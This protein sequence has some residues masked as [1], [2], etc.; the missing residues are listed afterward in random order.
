MKLAILY[1]LLPLMASAGLVRLPLL[2]YEAGPS[3]M[4]R[5][6]TASW[7]RV[8]RHASMPNHQLRAAPV[9]GVCDSGGTQLSGYLDTAADKHFFFW[10][11]EAKNKPANGTAPMVVWLNGGPG[12]SSMVGALT[13]L[14]PCLVAPDGKSTVDNPYGWNQNANLL[15]IDQP[16]GTGFSHGSMVNNS[17]SAADD[18]VAML[19]LFYKTYPEYHAD[20]LHVFGESFAGHFIPAIGSAIVDHNAR[21]ARA[22]SKASDPANLHIPLT[23]IGIGN[24]L[25]DPKTQFKYYSKMACDSTYP[26]VLPQ[27]TCASMDGNHTACASLIDTCYDKQDP[28]S[29][30]FA[31]NICKIAITDPYDKYV[32]NNV[33]DVRKK[34]GEAKLCYPITEAASQFLNMSWVQHALNAKDTKFQEC[35]G[36]VYK[37][38]RAGYDYMRSYAGDLAKLLDEG[39]RT[40]IYAGDADWIC[41]WY[42]VKAVMQELE[43]CGKTSF[44]A[45]PDTKWSVG[46]NAAGELRTASNLS[47]LRVFEA[48]HMVPMD[49]PKAALQ[50]LDGWLAGKL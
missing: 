31:D 46:S 14:G 8:A 21:V 39:V 20:D 5:R 37:K 4:W 19:L 48:G 23:S 45:A 24:G 9:N 26:P 7:D 49:Q 30:R 29:C 43:W 38:F 2:N 3:P 47:F 16:V 11:F 22:G 42:G 6:D 25:I 15:V 28:Q 33:Y 12:C 44:N 36:D 50:M 40:L 35:S 10:F 13:E 32:D 41:N 1:A 17:R 34:C 18:L 27:D